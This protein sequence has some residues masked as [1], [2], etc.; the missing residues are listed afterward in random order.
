M[1]EVLFLLAVPL[2]K[3]TIFR[4]NPWIQSEKYSTETKSNYFITK[5]LVLDIKSIN[6]E[7]RL[8]FANT[9]EYVLAKRIHLEVLSQKSQ[10]FYMIFKMY[11]GLSI[12]LFIHVSKDFILINLV[13][14]S[15][16]FKF[17]LSLFIKHNGTYLALYS[18]SCV[19]ALSSWDMRSWASLS[20]LCLS[21]DAVSASVA[22]CCTLP[23]SSLTS[24]LCNTHSVIDK[25]CNHIL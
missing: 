16:S 20:S 19:L 12:L 1:F 3:Q 2:I 17:M 4:R 14:V 9:Y 24:T 22:S 15:I 5:A 11:Y 21:W 13:T 23:S 8:S 6:N 7:Y 10:I 25:S 18:A